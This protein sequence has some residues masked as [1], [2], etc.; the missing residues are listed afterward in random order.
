[1]CSVRRPCVL[2]GTLLCCLAAAATPG[3]AQT[4]PTPNPTAPAKLLVFLD[5]Q[6]ECDTDYILQN[7]QFLD[8]VRDRTVAEVHVLVTS[9]P[10]GGGGRAW[11]L[12][13][14]GQGRFQN[15]TS[16]LTFTTA[17]TAT[18]DDRRK[19]FVRVFKLGLVPFALETSVAPQLDVNWTRPAG[20]T[21]TPGARDPWNYWVFRIGGGGNFNGE[22][23]STNRS[24]R[25]NFSGNRTTEAWK[26]TFFTG[27]NRNENRF[28]TS[29]GE[30]IR[31]E[32]DNWNGNVLIVKSVRAQWAAGAEA[33][34][35]HSTFS[36]TD[37]ALAFAPGIEYD[38]FPYR[39]WSRK[40]LTLRY[41]IGA[42]WHDYRSLTIFDRLDEVVPAH[43]LNASLGLRQPWGSLGISARLSEHL[44][45]LDRYRMSFFGNT[46]VRLFKGFSF[47]FF[48]EY[49]KIRDL[50]GLEKGD[51]STED[52]LLRIRQF[53][54]GYSYFVNFG[55]SYSFG[56]IF[57]S[58]VNPRFG[59]N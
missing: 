56:S 24:L 6:F 48:G 23:T 40:S 45:A 17:T 25:F 2:L 46:D 4:P 32:S 58:V 49:T 51:A 9:E 37:R 55:I 59:G 53:A 14:I 5:C 13:F 50:I 42:T 47:D 39:D 57:N 1:M 52:L 54:T 22:E 3:A 38:F 27:A 44:N 8:Y 7:V 10:T 21:T 43:H 20:G 11:T 12:Q 35:S 41:T 15:R 36:N 18:D 19:E 30:V 29:D 28:H 33:S 31:S 26:I 34:V 16:T